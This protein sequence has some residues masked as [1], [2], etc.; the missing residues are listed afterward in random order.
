MKKI[1]KQ[2][3]EYI[4]A[5]IRPWNIAEYNSTISRLSG[6][7]HLIDNPGDLT[8]EV[9]SAINP[10]YIFFPHW[11]HKVPA[12]IVDRYECVCF[13]ETDLPYGRG[14]SPIQNLIV[15]GHRET[16]VSAIRMVSAVD[17]GP[18]YAKRPMSLHGLAEEVFIRTAGIVS[19]MIRNIIESEPTPK[20][21]TGVPITFKRR[22]PKN[23]QISK[24]VKN[25]EELFNHI[26]ML[27]AEE[28]PRAFLEYGRFRFEFSRPALR[29]GKVESTVNITY[30]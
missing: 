4:V 22:A 14:G 10:R 19:E 7:W 3:K 21:Q 17:A 25:L 11:S 18:V 27:D 2:K 8:F 20:A 23:S 30:L 16:V 1:K 13:H 24:N 15:R 29:T 6:I 12:E 26:R 5:T 9:L 28:Y